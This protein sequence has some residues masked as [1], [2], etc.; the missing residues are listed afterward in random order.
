M[1]DYTRLFQ[2]RLRVDNLSAGG[3]LGVDVDLKVE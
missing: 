2:L 3:N 1:Q